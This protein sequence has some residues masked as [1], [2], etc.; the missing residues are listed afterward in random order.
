MR[1]SESVT[2]GQVTG[3]VMYTGDKE[4]RSMF[5]KQHLVLECKKYVAALRPWSFTASFTPVALGSTLA[6]KCTMEFSI[7]SFV[8]ACLTAL[9]I[10]AAGNLVNT[11]YDYIRGIDSKTSD[12]KTLVDMILSPN[13]VARLGAIFYI[14]GCIGFLILT[15][16]TSAR[17]EHLALVYFGGLSSSFLYTGGFGL[18]Y[19][20]LGDILIIFTFGPLTVLFAYLSQCGHLSYVP[21]LFAIPL[22]LN[23]EAILHSNNVRDIDS[24]HEAGIVTLAILLGKTGS[25]FLFTALLFIPFILFAVMGMHISKWMFLPMICIFEAFNLE[26]QYMKGNL[27]ILPHQIAKLNLLMGILF[28]LSI[29][30]TDQSVFQNLL[31]K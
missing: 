3:E 5:S 12:D 6:F 4:R 25:Y 13:D 1:R 14:F 18:K 28:T 31:L 17:M 30:F 22:A 23:T 7:I 19:I 9:S 10:H 20:A 29:A 15:I 21:M 27:Q 8:I 24:D 16:T 26:R 2:N 11:Y